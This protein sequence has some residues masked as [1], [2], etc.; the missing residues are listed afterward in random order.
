MDVS[1]L[2]TD[3]W[4]KVFHKNGD[5]VSRKIAGELFLVPVS[6]NLANMQKMFTITPVAEDIWDLLDGQRNL[7]EVRDAIHDRYDVD[8]TQVDS[9]IQEFI[10]QL[11]E[12]GLIKE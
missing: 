3:I 2:N 8:G 12:A 10:A 9:D 1:G 4:T 6:G 11:L 7:T 5:I